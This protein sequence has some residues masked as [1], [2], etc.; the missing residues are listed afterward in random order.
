MILVIVYIVMMGIV[1]LIGICGNILI[2]FVLIVMKG[3]NKLGKEFIIN[4]VMVDICVMV[5][6]EF[7]CIIGMYNIFIY[8]IIKFFLV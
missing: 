2:F 3:I 6:V 4:L 1:I 8:L 7:L 5:I